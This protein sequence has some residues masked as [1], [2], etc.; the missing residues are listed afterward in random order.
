MILILMI[1]ATIFRRRRD[2]L[3]VTV[4]SFRPPVGTIPAGVSHLRAYKL[5]IGDHGDDRPKN[6]PLH[7]RYEGQSP[8]LGAVVLGEEREMRHD[9][10][11]LA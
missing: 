4:P 5:T 1:T 2:R 8:S 6:M 3:L 10:H 7:G 11:R 9:A